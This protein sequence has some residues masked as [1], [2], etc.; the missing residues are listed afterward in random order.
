MGGDDAAKV[1]FDPKA[2]STLS[3]EELIALKARY[4]SFD[5]ASEV[6]RI[7]EEVFGVAPI[8][9]G[10]FEKTANAFDHLVYA[11]EVESD[12]ARLPI[13]VRINAARTPEKMLLVEEAAY[14]LLAAHDIPAPRVYAAAL[15]T[16]DRTYDYMVMQRIGS[17]SLESLL[18]KDASFDQEYARKAG[19]YLAQIHAIPLPGFGMIGE[20]FRGVHA[21]WPEALRIRLPE[22]LAYLVEQQLLSEDASRTIERIFMQEE[23]MP[24]AGA[25]LH[26]DFHPAN[27]IVDESDRSVAGAI[28][29]SQAKVGDPLFDIAFYATYASEERLAAFLDGYGRALTDEDRRLLARYSLRIYLS[30][31]KLRKRFGYEERTPAALAGIE[32]A[33]SELA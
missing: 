31:A 33:L 12:G 15:R 26:G 29:L 10:P 28:D 27:I 18:A 4:S 7:I 11:A 14:K 3:D 16:G 23:P 2:D 9:W 19:A 20:G 5:A 25:L 24:A 17:T 22:T 6:P 1:I 8:S 32:R 13:V 30:K 21:S